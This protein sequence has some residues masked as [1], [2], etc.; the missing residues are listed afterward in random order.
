MST[1]VH[2]VTVRRKC[3]ACQQES[4]GAAIILERLRNGV[5]R[6]KGV[7]ALSLNQ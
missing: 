2:A 1:S 4:G 7:V 3:F 5:N 6:P